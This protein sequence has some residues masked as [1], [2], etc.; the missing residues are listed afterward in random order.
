MKTRLVVLFTAV[1]L[2][3]VSISALGIYAD[4]KTARSTEN[5]PYVLTVK[6]ECVVIMKN[7]K[8]LER[9]D[10]VNYGALP[11]YDRN[12]LKEGIIFQSEDELYSVIEDFDG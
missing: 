3:I 5:M 9:L 7:G 12:Q 1:I 8:I 2:S 6:D 10:T 4:R 11:E